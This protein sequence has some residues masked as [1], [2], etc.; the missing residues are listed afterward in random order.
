MPVKHPIYL[1][2]HAEA[3]SKEEHPDRPLTPR[4]RQDTEQVAALAATLGVQVHE[5][6]HSGKTRAEQTATIFRETLEPA[7]GIVKASGL[8][9]LDDVAP[10]AQ[11]LSQASQPIMLVGHLPFMERLAGHMLTG[12]AE[13]PVVKFY[14]AGLVCLTREKERWQIKWIITPSVARA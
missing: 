14:N 11:A 9:P 3:H 5:I 7:A 6:R 1:V 2:Q 10:V 8:G 13:Q 4:G 12:D